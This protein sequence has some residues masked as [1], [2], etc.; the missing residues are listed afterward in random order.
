MVK[1]E[2]VA[3]FIAILIYNFSFFAIPEGI[4]ADTLELPPQNEKIVDLM[5]NGLGFETGEI[6]AKTVALLGEP[7]SEESTTF[8]NPYHDYK[9]EMTVYT[10]RGLEVVYIKNHH[11]DYG[12]DWM[13][14]VKVTHNE[15]KLKYGIK[16]G[17]E[18]S[19]IVKT[20]GDQYTQHTEEG[21]K[22]LFYLPPDYHMPQIVFALKDGRLVSVK[23][24]NMPD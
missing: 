9:N 20:F 19:E 6:R 2:I 3:S 7:L 15:W 14:G 17:M 23:W 1:R 24:L 12:Q 10:W 22:Y 16:L 4:S 11:P 13:V 21:L 8:D 18:N 5:E